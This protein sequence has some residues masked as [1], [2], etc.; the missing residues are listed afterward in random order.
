MVVILLFVSKGYG[1]EMEKR[2]EALR[3]G[4]AHRKPSKNVSY[5]ITIATLI[6][7]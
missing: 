6:F 1:N 3:M 4:L 7:F 2:M 5:F